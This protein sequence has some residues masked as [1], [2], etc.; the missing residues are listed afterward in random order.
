MKPAANKA[1]NSHG[2]YAPPRRVCEP[3]A[4]SKKKQKECTMHY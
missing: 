3:L 1:Y 4:A 2:G